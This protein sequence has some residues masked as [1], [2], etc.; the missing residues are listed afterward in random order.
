MTKTVRI[1]ARITPLHFEK[2]RSMQQRTGM[3][4]SQIIRI[5]IEKAELIQE[6]KF[7]VPVN[8]QALSVEVPRPL[9]ES[10]PLTIN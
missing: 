8:K 3:S 10:A 9:T 7:S 2:I 5:L 6:P 4:P 1:E